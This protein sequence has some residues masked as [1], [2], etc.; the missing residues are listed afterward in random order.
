MCSIISRHPKLSLLIAFVV[1][2]LAEQDLKAQLADTVRSE[3]TVDFEVRPRMEYRDNFRWTAADTVMPELYTTQRNRLSVSYRSDRLRLHV[4][5]QEI[6][7]WGDPGR[8]SRTGSLNFFEAYAEPVISKYLSVRVG[9]QALSLDNGRIFSAAPWAQQS[10]SHEGI[11]LLFKKNIETDLTFAFTRLYDKH[12]EPAYSPVA[13]HS[14]KYLAVHH[15]KH[16]LPQNITM[17]TI[18]AIDMFRRVNGDKPYYLRVTNGGRFEF[19]Q[20][21]FYGAVNAYY[22]YGKNEASVRIRAYY[23]QS[24]LSVNTVKTLFRLGVEILS[25]DTNRMSKGVS[26]SFV[27][28]YGVAWKFMGN[29]NLF[30]RFP[31]DVN[32][33]GLVNPYLFAIL[34]ANNRLSL[35]LDSH[36]FFSMHPLLIEGVE[37]DGR[38]LGFESDLSM[39][40]KPVTP[41]EINYGFCVTLASQRMELLGKV[42]DT[43]K[44]P[45]WSYVMISYAPRLFTKKWLRTGV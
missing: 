34:Q 4:S 28:L 5:P 38:Y 25:G 18:N 19:Y 33:K 22:Q 12:F 14:Y 24:E 37:T 41:I 16:R 13:S 45:V 23:I 40:Y 15:F 42:K 30:T 3:L 1:I 35:R 11:R 44:I 7:V 21:S 39:N 8:F 20:N 2:I 26:G 43:G 31:A 6:H 32:G 10:R 36:L 9:R 29:M 17:T 27:P